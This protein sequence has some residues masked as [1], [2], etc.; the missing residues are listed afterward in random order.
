M[1]EMPGLGAGVKGQRRVQSQAATFGRAE[2]VDA[3]EN[4]GRPFAARQI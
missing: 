1:I 3:R 2:R 4:A